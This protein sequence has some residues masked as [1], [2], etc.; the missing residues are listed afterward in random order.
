MRSDFGTKRNQFHIGQQR[1]RRA[2]R[3]RTITCRRCKQ[4]R[5]DMYYGPLTSRNR[6]AELYDE[7]AV[8]ALNFFGILEYLAP[9]D[10]PFS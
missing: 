4:K 7:R 5:R 3:D 9:T 10:E 1:R 2:A 6:G 8:V